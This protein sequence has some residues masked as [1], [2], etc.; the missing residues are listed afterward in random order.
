V[1]KRLTRIFY[2]A[3]LTLIFSLTIASFIYAY[4]GEWIQGLNISTA[5]IISDLATPETLYATTVGGLYKSTDRGASWE[6]T[7]LT[8][9]SIADIAISPSDPERI[10]ANENGNTILRSENGGDTWAAVDENLNSNNIRDLAVDESSSQIVYAATLGD[11]MFKSI[12]SGCTLVSY[13]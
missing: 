11:G 5:V 2:I 12:D 7:G 10:Y 6:L 1:T 13:Q 3:L 8:S 4:E 9:S